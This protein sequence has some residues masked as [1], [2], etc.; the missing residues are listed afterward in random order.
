MIEQIL[1]KGTWEKIN[2]RNQTPWEAL[3]G[4]SYRRL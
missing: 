3:M 4:V 2:K 1:R